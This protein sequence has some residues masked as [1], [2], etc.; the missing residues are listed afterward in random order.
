MIRSWRTWLIVLLGLLAGGGGLGLL[1]MLQGAPRAGGVLLYLANA[2]AGLWVLYGL[3]VWRQVPWVRRVTGWVI[4]VV[5]AALTVG[6]CLSLG[7]RGGAIATVGAFAM[8]AGFTLGLALIRALL[9]GGHPVA[10][11]ARTLVDEAI[12]MKVAVVFIVALV[13]LVPVLPLSLD[14]GDPLKY[15]LQMFLSWS[16]IITSVLLSLMTIFL[17]VGTVSREVEQRQIFLTM[18]KP[19]SRAQYLLGK[20]LGVA[21]LNL[22]LV[23]V[24]GA[25]VYVFTKMLARQPAWDGAD[26][27]AVDEQVLVA[28]VSLAPQ[29]ADPAV[30]QRAYQERLVQLQAQEPQV[31]GPPGTPLEQVPQELRRQIQQHLM[32]QWFTVGPRQTQVF[33]FRDPRLLHS[34]GRSIQLRLEPKAAGSTSD[35]FVRLSMRVNGRPFWPFGEPVVKLSVDTYHMLEIPTEVVSP[36]GTLELAI[37]N[38]AVDEQEQPSISFDPADGLQVLYRVGGF[39]ANL[40]R[41]LAILWV[42]LCFLAAL[43]LAASTFLGFPIACVLCLMVYVAAAGSGYLHESMEYYAAFPRDTLTLWEKIVWIPQQFVSLMGE[44]KVYDAVKILVRLLGTAFL[45]LVPSFSDYN[46]TPLL[47]EGLL[48]PWRQL[49]RAVLEVGVLWTGTAAVI[50]WLIF[51]RREL[52]QVTV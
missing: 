24:S 29:P 17:A 20:W 41:S 6:F 50:G 21:L 33:V 37:S 15:R 52:A 39:E 12:R 31:Y 46:P 35:G 16:M 27:L 49:G 28:R 51:R 4:G 32:S 22:L 30:I 43:G 18:T 10:G 8:A 5:V 19:V 26:R 34:G 9:R 40:F 38:P 2:L 42:R 48:V 36:E 11:V 23:S 13:L 3:W 7:W 25:G 45:K 44:G 14:E 1:L 47:A